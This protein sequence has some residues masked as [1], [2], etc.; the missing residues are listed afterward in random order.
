MKTSKKESVELRD[1]HERRCLHLAVASGGR[2]D[3]LER[4]VVGAII[5]VEQA[6]RK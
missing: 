2:R 6:H 3:S 5:T 4:A 1:R